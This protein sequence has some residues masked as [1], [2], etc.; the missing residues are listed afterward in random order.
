MLGWWESTFEIWKYAS[1]LP[2]SDTDRL[3][4]GMG[5]RALVLEQSRSAGVYQRLLTPAAPS[6]RSPSAASAGWGAATTPHHGTGSEGWLKIMAPGSNMWALI[7][8]SKMGAWASSSDERCPKWVW[9]ACW[10]WER[11]RCTLQAGHVLSLEWKKVKVGLY[12]FIQESQEFSLH[13]YT[14]CVYVFIHDS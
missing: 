10:Q 11:A 7:T 5:H 6:W 1:T 13:S 12:N 4:E 8:N 9:T 3:T 14:F 2:L